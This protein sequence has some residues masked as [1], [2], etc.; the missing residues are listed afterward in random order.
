MKKINLLKGL[1]LVLIGAMFS[2]TALTLTMITKNEKAKSERQVMTCEMALR[3]VEIRME[4]ND[5][6]VNY[7]YESDMRGEITLDKST[8]FWLGRIE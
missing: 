4:Q 1:G 7:L 2:S 8:I 6:I 3:E 5:N